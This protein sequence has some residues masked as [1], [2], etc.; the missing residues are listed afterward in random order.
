MWLT[1]FACLRFCEIIKRLKHLF[2]YYVGLFMAGPRCLAATVSA[3]NYLLVPRDGVTTAVVEP[4]HISD[5]L[6]IKLTC[7]VF[8]CRVLLGRTLFNDHD[9]KIVQTLH[10]WLLYAINTLLAIIGKIVPMIFVQCVL[11][12][13]CH[14]FY[15]PY[16]MPY[17]MP[18]NTSLWFPA[19]HRVRLSHWFRRKRR[20][21]RRS[22]VGNSA[23]ST[24]LPTKLL[25]ACKTLHCP[26]RQQTF[27]IQWISC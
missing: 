12:L 1:K 13:L 15:M 17:N 2:S 6:L 18:C 26:L 25:Y 23:L 9:V 27:D 4:L 16:T 8:R 10:C 11:V 7:V 21:S 19:L 24:Y 20:E 14:P 3:T 22:M 5:Q